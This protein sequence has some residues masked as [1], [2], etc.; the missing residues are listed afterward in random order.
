MTVLVQ[1]FSFKKGYP[2]D[3][4]GHG[5][6]F[7]FDCRGLPNPHHDPELRD[8][9][10]KQE[11][12]VDFLESSARVQEFWENVR[13]MVDMQVEDY[14]SREFSSLTVS[15]GCTGGKHRSVF[16]AEK[17]ANHLRLRFPHVTLKTGHREL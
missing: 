6:G 12:V 3:K 7:V 16:M 4:E 14:L 10:G 5:G 2:E 8:F 11:P 9:T 1:S 17:L 15:F 13:G